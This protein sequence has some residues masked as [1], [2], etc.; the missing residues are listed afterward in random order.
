MTQSTPLIQGVVT[1]H[2]PYGFYVKFGAEQEGLVVITMI[3]DDP[4]QSNPAFPAVGTVV[5]ARLLGTT[6]IGR[7]PRLSV[8][9]MDVR[10]AQL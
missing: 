7:Q 5:T 10:K 3:S 2:E 4:L 1:R 8:R 6:A 9:P